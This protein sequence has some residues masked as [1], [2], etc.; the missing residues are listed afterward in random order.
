MLQVWREYF[1]V[2]V[3]LIETEAEG[4]KGVRIDDT[5]N[6]QS[7]L[8]YEISGHPG[9][10]MFLS[11][12]INSPIKNIVPYPVLQPKSVYSLTEITIK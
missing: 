12:L 2:Y 11:L 3:M 1:K 5:P 6:E 9:A 7:C 8:N 4:W 10:G